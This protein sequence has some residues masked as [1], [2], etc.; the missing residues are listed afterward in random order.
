MISIAWK[1]TKSM[2]AK[3][4]LL[5]YLRRTKRW[6]VFK[7]LVTPPTDDGI[8]GGLGGRPPRGGVNMAGVGLN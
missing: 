7:T 2:R 1:T 3:H 4:I 5:F 8:T 6:A